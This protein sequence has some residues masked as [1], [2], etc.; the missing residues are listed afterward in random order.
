MSVKCPKQQTG[1]HFPK[2][3]KSDLKKKSQKR[4]V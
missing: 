4:K 1:T 2:N 3:I